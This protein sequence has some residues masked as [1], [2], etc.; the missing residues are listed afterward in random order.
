MPNFEDTEIAFAN[1]SNAKLRKAYYIFQFFQF[2][3]LVNMGGRL[4]QWGLKWHLPVG[5]FAKPT[6]FGQ[7]VGG[8]TLRETDSTVNRLGKS[9]VYGILDYAIEGKTTERAFDDTLAHKLE[10][11]R[12][13]KNNPNVKMI[14]AKVT[15][16]G[17]FSL[18]ERVHRGDVLLQSEQKEYE[19]LR[20]RLHKVCAAALDASTGILFDAEETWI[21][22]PLDSLIEEMMAHYNKEKAIVYNTYQL[23]ATSRLGKLKED[24]EKAQKEGYILG[25]KLVRGAYMEK[26]RE[27]AAEMG[28]PSPIHVDKDAVDKDYNAGLDYCLD[29]FDNGMAFCAATHNED[30][31]RYL[32]EQ[33][34]ARGLP[35]N[36]KYMFFA[37]LYGMGDHIT[38]NL[39]KEGYTAAK[40]I[41]FGPVKEVIPYLVRR[42]Q[43]N[44]SVEG[45]TSRE[46]NILTKEMKRRKL[47]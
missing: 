44:S 5:L 27:R 12:Y 22:G 38:F 21:Q 16:L 31:C 34:V 35:K 8:V 10:M 2:N 23:Y 36:H 39:A 13:V 37:Q 24:Y 28:Y 1:T 20:A 6:I 30:S 25:A 18:L 29:R 9:G 40:L 46:L 43:E 42:A 17:K 15:G 47:L 3:S 41:P 14:S 33:I 19:R 45:Q 7:F 4:A 26:E 11:L 32:A